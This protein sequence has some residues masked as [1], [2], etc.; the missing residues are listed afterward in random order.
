VLKYALKKLAGQVVLARADVNVSQKQPGALKQ[1]WAARLRMR[2]TFNAVQQ[3]SRPF[4]RTKKKPLHCHYL[5]VFRVIRVPLKLGHAFELVASL[6]RALEH[7][8]GAGHAQD[9]ADVVVLSKG[10]SG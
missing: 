9:C 8:K 6:G 2:D 3:R 1:E 4:R 7:L 5:K 10:I